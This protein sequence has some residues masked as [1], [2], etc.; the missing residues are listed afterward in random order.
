MHQGAVVKY[1]ALIAVLAA[2][3]ALLALFVRADR[4][5]ATPLAKAAAAGDA[6]QVKDLITSGADVNER[7]REGYTAIMAAARYGRVEAIK[8]LAEAK[9]DVNGRD[10]G[11]NGWTPLLHAVHKRQ[12]AAARALIE[13]GADVNARGGDCAERNVENGPTPLQFA[14]MYDD[15]EMVKLLLAHG[16]DPRR[17]ADGGVL[18][19]ALGGAA[20]GKLTDID[21]AGGGKCPTE[22]VKA[23]L[24][25]APDLTLGRGFYEGAALKII[26]MKGCEE[27]VRLLEKRP[28]PPEGR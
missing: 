14:A 4:G 16:A 25:K 18:A 19:Y 1:L 5:P 9:A 20:F 10:C 15:A 26:R 22:T 11:T 23:L 13:G 17:A 24:E 6:A 28:R 8:A 21:R 7:D 12:L 27:V 3:A 2:A